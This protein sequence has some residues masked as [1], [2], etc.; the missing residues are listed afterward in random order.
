MVIQLGDFRKFVNFLFA[1]NRVLSS[2]IF[3]EFTAIIINYKFNIDLRLPCL[4]TYFFKYNCFGCHLSDAFI[5]LIKFNF[6]KAFQ[7]NFLIYLVLIGAFY[8]IK[9]Q[10]DIYNVERS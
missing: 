7:I 9:N 5:Q 4:F 2:V 8:H 10:F 6:L 1:K 3:F